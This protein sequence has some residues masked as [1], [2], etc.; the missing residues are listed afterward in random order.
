MA[1]EVEE[2]ERVVE[3]NKAIPFAL[4]LLFISDELDRALFECAFVTLLELFHEFFLG[5]GVRHVLDHDIGP[6]VLPHLD[7]VYLLVSYRL[8]LH[9]LAR[10]ERRTR[11][12]R[13]LRRVYRSRLLKLS[14]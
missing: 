3:V 12:H 5:V 14:Y 1:V 11:S 4:I 6:H 2:V 7:Y 10:A 13:A 8:L 9:V